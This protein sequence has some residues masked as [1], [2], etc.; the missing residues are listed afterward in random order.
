M[1]RAENLREQLRQM[2]RPQKTSKR[3]AFR[4]SLQKPRR[5]VHKNRR[6]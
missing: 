2:S 1:K 4:N 3:L 5:K 6:N